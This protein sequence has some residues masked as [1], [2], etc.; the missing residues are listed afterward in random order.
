VQIDLKILSNKRKRK[1]NLVLKHNKE[2]KLHICS[3]ERNQKP[4]T[5]PAI[6]HKILL[7]T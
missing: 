1:I 7:K 2:L 6:N 4:S 3:E 5:L